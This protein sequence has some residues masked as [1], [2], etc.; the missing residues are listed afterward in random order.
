MASVH[1][2]AGRTRRGALGLALVLSAIP[3][4]RCLAIPTDPIPPARPAASRPRIGPRTPAT[5]ARSVDPAGK[6]TAWQDPTPP[7]ANPGLAATPTSP[8]REPSIPPSPTY[9]IDL[10]SALKLAEAVNPIIGEARTRVDEAMALRLKARAIL[11]PNL[12]LGGDYNGHSGVY[13]RSSGQILNVARQSV[14]LGGGTGVSAQGTIEIPAVFIAAHL[15]DAIYEPLAARQRVDAAEFEA[16]GT[17]NAVLLGVAV[18]YLELQAAGALIDARRR[19]EA[20]AAEVARIAAAY[21]RT[22][23]GRLADANRA[24]T[25]RQ[26]RSAEVRRAEERLG[27]ASARLARRLH[28]DPSSRIEPAGQ[29]LAVFPLVDLDASQE[30]MIEVAE[31][32]RPE[33]LAQSAAIMVAE[34]RARQEKSRPFLP[35]IQLGFSGGV[36]GGGSNYSPPL[37]GEFRGRTDFDAIAYWSLLNFGKGNLAL[38]KQ[39][40]AVVGTAVAERD[41]TINIVR[42]QVSAALAEARAK[43]DQIQIAIDELAIA[44]EGYRKDLQRI[45]AAA[46]PPLEVLNNLNLLRKAREALIEAVL[47]FNVAQFQLFVALGSPPPLELPT[48]PAA[49]AETIQAL[50]ANPIQAVLDGLPE[51]AAPIAAASP[52]PTTAAAIQDSI[53]SLDQAKQAASRANRDYERLQEELIRKL[54]EP[55]GAANREELLRGLAALAEAHRGEMSANIQYD[56]ALWTLMASPSRDPN[57]DGEAQQTATAPLSP[58][59]PQR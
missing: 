14:Y 16:T 2:R 19:T 29:M 1:Q 6:R 12:N 57:R 39:R 22:G 46:A 30:G 42:D 34:T 27:V 52:A 43:R 40:N 23:E 33:I 9:P 53:A 5:A 49:S 55:G 47:G 51:P 11:L 3:T 35:T 44:Q 56:K 21:A 58:P 45:Q 10:P 25:Q 50:V 54:N 36:F 28:L 15:T 31:R 4:P 48:A 26:L 7:V 24:T 18:E 20:E 13:Q 37:L 38:I 17:A 41:R 8:S 59:A 32:R